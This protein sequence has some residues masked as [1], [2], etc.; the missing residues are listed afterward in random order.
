MHIAQRGKRDVITAAELGFVH[1]S[2][3]GKNV[4][5]EHIMMAGL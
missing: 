1:T 4:I 5:R 3:D 2:R